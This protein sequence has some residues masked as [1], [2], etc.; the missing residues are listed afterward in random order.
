MSFIISKPNDLHR[1]SSLKEKPNA[2]LL[3]EAGWIPSEDHIST[4]FH[5][6]LMEFSS[7]VVRDEE[8]EAWFEGLQRHTPE[9]LR[10][11]VTKKGISHVELPRV[12][13][14][15]F[16]SGKLSTSLK[17]LQFENITFGYTSCIDFGRVI[18]YF[19]GLTKLNIY[20][21]VFQG[22]I[23]VAICESSKISKAFWGFRQKTHHLD[24]FRAVNT[25]SYTCKALN[26]VYYVYVAEVCGINE[27][28]TCLYRHL[29]SRVE[30]NARASTWFT[31][32]RKAVS[33]RTELRTTLKYGI[34]LVATVLAGSLI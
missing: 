29:F 13:P 24:L 9:N 14:K 33:G 31:L 8:L 10:K 19:K 12:F 32:Y 26:G 2:V 4:V 22:P 7:C 3:R 25:D 16:L 6:N 15:L 21:C 18:P 28:E 11:I 20:R 30:K 27:L 34:F 23:S 17:E 1:L 5:P